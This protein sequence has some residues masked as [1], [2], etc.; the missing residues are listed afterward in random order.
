MD[1]V[2]RHLLIQIQEV[3]RLLS[4]FN[5][6][7]IIYVPGVGNNDALQAR[8]AELDIANLVSAISDFVQN[9]TPLSGLQARL[10][11]SALVEQNAQAAIQQIFTIFEDHLRKRIGAPSNLYGKDLIN[12]SFG[13]NGVLTYGATSA[14]KEGVRSLFFGAYATFRN[15]HMHRI[16]ENDSQMVL[17]IISLVDMLIKITDTAQDSIKEE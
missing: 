16:V 3:H 5:I 13:K 15:P 1:K 9:T 14:E 17:S 12:Q 7:E 6:K 10:V 8:I 11:T 4:E 2:F